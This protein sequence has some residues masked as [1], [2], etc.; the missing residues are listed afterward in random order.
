MTVTLKRL[1]HVNLRT[2]DLDAM[3]AWYGRVLDM[4]PGPRPDFAFPGAWLY[5]DGHPIIHLVGVETA[6]RSDPAADLRLAHFAIS[7][8][9][10]NDLRARLDAEGAPCRL[11]HIRDLGIV[12]A[13]I[14]DPDGNHIHID[15]D[16]AEA[17]GLGL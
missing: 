7:A 12:Q 5:A 2:A 6:P 15:F 3:V 14:H 9:D 11:A 17:E 13:N 4:H 8:N 1:D 10:L 16:A